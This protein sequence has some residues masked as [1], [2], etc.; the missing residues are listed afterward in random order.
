[1]DPRLLINLFLSTPAAVEK[2]EQKPTE[3]QPKQTNQC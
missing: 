3:Q 2:H 1:M